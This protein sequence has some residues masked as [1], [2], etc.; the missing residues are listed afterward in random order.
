[1]VMQ[2]FNFT[3]LLLICCF[4]QLIGQHKQLQN[5]G[6]EDGL[7]QSQVYDIVQ[8]NIGY[9]WLGT[10]GGGISR[11]DGNEFV[12][13][14]TKNGLASNFIN[15]LYLKNDSL[16][17]GTNEGISIKVK[18]SFINIK[19]PKIIKII[20][21]KNNLLLATT[22]GVYS[23]GKD[24]LQPLQINPQIDLSQINDLVY[25]S[26]FYWIATHNGLWKATDLSINGNTTLLFKGNYTSLYLHNKKLI[27]GSVLNGLQIIENDKI[28]FQNYAFKHP[29]HIQKLANE[30]WI[31][32][33]NNGIFSLDFKTLSS[34]KKINLTA[35]TSLFPIKKVLIDA[36]NNTWIATSGNGLFKLTSNQFIHIDAKSGLTNHRI[37]NIH[38]ANNAIWISNSKNQ[39]IKNDSLGFTTIENPIKNSIITSISSD[40]TSAIWTST[41]ENGIVIYRE[42]EVDSLEQNKWK[43]TTL[44]STNG[45]QYNNLQQIITTKNAVWALTTNK[46][47]V[48]L[49]YNFEQGFLEKSTLYNSKNGIADLAIT[50][51]ALD[52]HETI[53]YTTKNGSV[54]FIKDNKVDHFHKI[55]NENILVNT[56]LIDK[57]T[58]FFGTLGKGIWIADTNDLQEVKPLKGLKELSSDNVYQLIFDN[59]HNLWMGTENGVDKITLS[60]NNLL[61]DVYHFNKNDGFQGMETTKNAVVKDS[62]GVIWFGTKNGITKYIPSKREVLEGKPIVHFEDIK[63]NFK[64]LNFTKNLNLTQERIYL[65]PTKNNISF[66]FKTVDI[67][68]PK[69]IVYRWKLNSEFSP[70]STQNTIELANLPSG[71]YTFT[72]QSRNKNLIESDLK[73]FVFFI[74]KPLYEK[75]WF[76]V[77]VSAILFFVILLIF[78]QYFRRRQKENQQKIEKLTLENHLITLEQKALQL[79]MNPHFIFN[80]L[81]GIKALGNSGKS[82]E[83]NATISKFSILLRAILHNSRKEEISLQ[84]EIVT[85]KT[86]VELEQQM[87]L[88]SF[89]FSIK[90]TVNNIDLEEILIPP[91]L[92]QP[93]VE[94]SI[95]HAFTSS[96][97]T[98][99]IEV[100]FEIKNK[101]LSCTI[102]DNG[103]GFKHS[104]QKKETNHSS[105]A[106]KI[107]KERIESLSKNASFTINEII[108]ESKIIGT[109][110]IFIIPLKT[111]Y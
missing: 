94:N 64:S 31:S 93:F 111:D 103:I 46:G 53:W 97:E 87:S 74:D 51:I 58:A 70:W 107:T 13:F 108:E 101:F 89:N 37:T 72:I 95:K 69:K 50:T 41:L 67:N 27:A 38:A 56:L 84:E 96:S 57:N 104:Q 90:T 105:A 39:L 65:E 7:P 29:I 30:Y 4:S 6:I 5:F 75:T 55:F 98:P 3:F 35:D 88:N 26:D 43:T 17:I 81:N 73:S 19:G 34:F 60:E 18:D 61:L 15:A 68:H 62:L 110:V 28:T 32:T 40:S 8:D 100:S 1:M 77:S 59:E 76:I 44:N 36:Q 102:V 42:Q 79:Q 91:M 20:P 47:I 16:F 9:V 106:L 66:R 80:V 71:D 54:G 2:R 45:F 25:D 10:Q 24:Y 22:Q 85:L 99:K 52:E 48:K 92:I 11:F 82:E 33:Q 63:V 23:V 14:T 83:L 49:D 21:V 109:K 12:N 86:Y 78:F